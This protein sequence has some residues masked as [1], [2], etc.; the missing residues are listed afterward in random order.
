MLN[1]W[2]VKPR[3]QKARGIFLLAGM[4]S[5]WLSQKASLITNE[6]QVGT[7]PWSDSAM[8]ARPCPVRPRHGFVES[9]LV[10]NRA[11]L[12]GVWKEATQEDPEAEVILMP[13]LKAKG[14]AVVTAKMIAIGPGHDGATAGK[15]CLE[16][17]ISGFQESQFP[18]IV[19]TS[20]PSWTWRTSRGLSRSEE[21]LLL[22]AEVTGF[23]RKLR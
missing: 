12:L 4:D 11:Q 9:R 10:H 6:S 3:T 8:F 23:R 16:I 17:P 18:A 2:A 7:V 14:N 21:A 13:F 19:P 1:T 5:G 15:N 22:S 20:R